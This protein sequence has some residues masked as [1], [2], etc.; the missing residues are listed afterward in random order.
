VEPLN[1]SDLIGRTREGM[2][3]MQAGPLA[4]YMPY[5]HGTGE[6]L[7]CL[8]AL[9]PKTLAV[10]HGSSFR[11]DCGQALTELGSV[12]KETFGERAA[13]LEPGKLGVGS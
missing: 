11:G 8:A 13:G 7:Q 5:T 4:G 10:M 12:I 9:Q 6:M 2:G 1:G 3:R